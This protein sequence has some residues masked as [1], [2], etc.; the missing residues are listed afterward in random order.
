[1]DPALKAVYKDKSIRGPS[2][3]IMAYLVALAD[4]HSICSPGMRA[5]YD[6]CGVAENTAD[7]HMKALIKRGYI[8]KLHSGNG[9]GNKSAILVNPHYTKGVKFIPLTV[10]KGVNSNPL[11]VGK[12]GQIWG[13]SD[14]KG[15]QNQPPFDS[16]RGSNMGGFNTETPSNLGAFDSKRGSNLKVIKEEDLNNNNNYA[17][18]IL[19]L[20]SEFENL[21]MLS[22]PHGK[23]RDYRAKWETPLSKF[24]EHC[25]G[26]VP[27]ATELIKSAI[28]QLRNNGNG[29]RYTIA[30]PASLDTVISNLVSQR[31]V[32][33]DAG[34]DYGQ[35]FDTHFGT[36]AAQNKR[37]RGELPEEIIAV[38]NKMGRGRF[39][40]CTERDKSRL[41]NDF[42]NIARQY[43]Q[44]PA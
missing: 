27:A 4:E 17:T 15:G 14:N 24:L 39:Q 38:V 40:S 44:V 34:P 11:P 29:K 6:E 22:P 8:K 19:E 43:Q 5:I 42:I 12:G 36:M 28:D 21:T 37:M 18:P 23:T 20:I 16:Q 13:A 1:M 33:L 30:S 9:S 26:D 25:G 7:K 32:T 10:Q 41:R 2:K 31:S 35:L 3:A